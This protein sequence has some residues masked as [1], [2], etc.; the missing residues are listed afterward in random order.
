[1]TRATMRHLARTSMPLTAPTLV[2]A[3]VI[4]NRGGRRFPA[5][6]I[7][8]Y[9]P[10]AGAAWLMRT[11]SSQRSASSKQQ[12]PAATRSA[13]TSGP[14]PPGAAG[15]LLGRP[16]YLDPN[17]PAV[18]LCARSMLFGGFSRYWVR[19]ANGIRFE[20]SLHY[21]LNSRLTTSK[22]TWRADGALID[23]TRAIRAFGGAVS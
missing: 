10:S 15:M 6:N 11:P 9:A 18:G 4:R 2:Q 17:V 16:V 22:A 19:K 3:P 1:M 14:T 7:I 13:L 8:D 5:D 23:T 12:G 20:Q 21:A